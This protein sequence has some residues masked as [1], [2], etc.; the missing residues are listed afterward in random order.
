M[1]VRELIEK[2]Q[3]MPPDA[4]VR[5]DAGEGVWADAEEVEDLGWSLWARQRVVS[6]GPVKP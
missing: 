4:I 2:L 1:T 6:I 5:T 3:A